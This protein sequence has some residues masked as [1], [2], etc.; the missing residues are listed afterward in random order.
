MRH[1]D[2][3]RMEHLPLG[4]ERVDRCVA[5]VKRVTPNR[6]PKVSEMDADLVR[7]ACVQQ[8]FH[9]RAELSLLQD[10]IIGPGR[11]TTMLGFNDRHFL[12]VPRMSSNRFADFARSFPEYSTT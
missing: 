9:I 2:P 5:S 11:P 8:T 4:T 7:A 6:M 12:A 10:A 1:L 3:R